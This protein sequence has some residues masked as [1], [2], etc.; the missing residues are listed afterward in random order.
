MCAAVGEGNISLSTIKR[1]FNR[2]KY[3]KKSLDDEERSGRPVSVDFQNILNSMDTNP[4]IS[5]RIL[6]G[7]VGCSQTS[8]QRHLMRL[9]KVNRRC[10]YILYQ[11]SSSQA[12][13]RL[14]NGKKYFSEGFG[15]RTLKHI[16]TRDEK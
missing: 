10:K 9:G 3:G 2:F 15:K 5:T 8:V 11:L 13:S 14:E 4:Q 16:V 12:K 7:E 6:S 1:W